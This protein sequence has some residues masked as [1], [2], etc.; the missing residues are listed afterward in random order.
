MII[1]GRT[2]ADLM[3]NPQKWHVPW[4]DVRRVEPLTGRYVHSTIV[5]ED[6]TFYLCFTLR[7]RRV[8]PQQVLAEGWELNPRRRGKAA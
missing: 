5:Y 2:L 6:G 4:L 3:Q 1:R 8:T 7:D